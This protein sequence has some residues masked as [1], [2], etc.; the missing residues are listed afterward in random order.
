MENGFSRDGCNVGI[1]SDAQTT[2]PITCSATISGLTI[3]GNYFL[4]IKLFLI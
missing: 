4:G 3:I 2:Y 1:S